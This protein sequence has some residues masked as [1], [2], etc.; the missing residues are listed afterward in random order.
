[1]H[2]ISLRHLF[3][4]LA[5]GA[6]MF[7]GVLA[8]QHSPTALGFTPAGVHHMADGEAVWPPPRTL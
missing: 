8:Q 2:R 7:A 5:L 4:S 3:L 1:M 6:G